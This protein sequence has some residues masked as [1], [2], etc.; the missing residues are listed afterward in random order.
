[1]ITFAGLSDL[2]DRK[3]WSQLTKRALPGAALQAS[4][5]QDRAHRFAKAKR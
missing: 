3:R 1:V 4:V 2:F 5:E